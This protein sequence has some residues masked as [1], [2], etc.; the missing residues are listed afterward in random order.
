[1][2]HDPTESS[3]AYLDEPPEGAPSAAV[4]ALSPFHPRW[5]EH[6]GFRA[7]LVEKEAFFDAVKALKDAGWSGFVDHTAVDYPARRPRLTVLVIL[8]NRETQD[9]LVVKTRTADGEPVASLTPLWEA[10]NW[11]ERETYDMFGVAF[12]GH[13]DLTRIYLPQSYDG[14]PM[15][16][17]FPLQGHLRF[18]D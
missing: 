5:S 17:D 11:A 9:R 7:V 10:A 6:H 14:W 2:K 16:R 4:A 15:R 3:I 1:M 8:M 13:P 18:R 12:E